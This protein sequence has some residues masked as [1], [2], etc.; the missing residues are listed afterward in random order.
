MLLLSS[1]KQMVQPNTKTDIYLFEYLFDEQKTHKLR[2][3]LLCA[4]NQFLI[5]LISIFH[6]TLLSELN[7]EIDEVEL[8]SLD[9]D[10]MMLWY[11]CCFIQLTFSWQSFYYQH[12]QS[13]YILKMLLYL[14]IRCFTISCN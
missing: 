12:K 5:H 14:M 1:A 13:Y 3:L 4:N 6:N 10:Y 2:K 11:C 7:S 8:N 9:S